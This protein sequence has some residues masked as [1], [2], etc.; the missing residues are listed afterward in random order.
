MAV[1]VVMVVIVEEVLSVEIQKPFF[2]NLGME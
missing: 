2:E 1:M